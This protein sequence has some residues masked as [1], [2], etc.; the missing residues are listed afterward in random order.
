MF[1]GVWKAS[2][3]HVGEQLYLVG[4]KPLEKA[5]GQTCLVR[6]STGCRK[7]FT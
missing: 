4:S 7:N 6:Q 3:V 5:K 1:C 2:K